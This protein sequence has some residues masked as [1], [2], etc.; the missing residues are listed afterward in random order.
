MREPIEATDAHVFA[1]SFY[2]E[3]FGMLE[4]AFADGQA[5][6]MEWAGAMCAARQALRKEQAGG[7][8]PAERH[9]KWTVPILCT[10]WGTLTVDP[11]TVH[12]SHSETEKIQQLK[13]MNTLA[14]GSAVRFRPGQEAAVYQRIEQIRATLGKKA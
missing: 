2:Q 6:E 14:R 5:R 3:V 9:R 7:L 1:A 10:G 13:E 11:V 12:P 8:A 4:E